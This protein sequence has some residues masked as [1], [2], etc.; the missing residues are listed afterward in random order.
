M[1]GRLVL[2]LLAFGSIMATPLLPGSAAAQD[3]LGAAAPLPA[4]D[5]EIREVM[6]PMRDGMALHTAGRVR[7]P[8]PADPD[9]V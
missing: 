8:N 4:R 9:A 7:R 5:Y 6:I 2:T 3:R 1:T